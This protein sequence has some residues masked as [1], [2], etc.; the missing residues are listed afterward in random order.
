MSQGAAFIF[1]G[2]T[3]AIFTVTYVGTGIFFCDNVT[4]QL[5]NS[6]HL[7]IAICYKLRISRVG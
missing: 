4:V 3:M 2:R 6:M 7:T 1:I 5:R